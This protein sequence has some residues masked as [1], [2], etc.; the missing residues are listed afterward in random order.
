MEFQRGQV[1]R[2]VRAVMRTT[3]PR[4]IWV[5][6]FYL[7][8]VGLVG[9]VINAV[10][11]VLAGG[12]IL[13]SPDLLGALLTNNYDTIVGNTGPGPAVPPGT[14]IYMTVIALV[15]ALL[16]NLWQSAMQVGY[17][18]YSMDL[19]RGRNPG[20]DKLFAMLRMA[21]PI[22]VTAF[23]V[24]LFSA[25]WAILFYVAG[26]I[27]VGIGAA[28]MVESALTILGVVLMIVALVGMV[29][30]ILWAVL[31]YSMVTY[32]IADQGISG[33][34]AIRES[35]R[36]MKGNLLKYVGLHLS[37]IL[38]YLPAIIGSGFLALTVSTLIGETAA[39]AVVGIFDESH[40]L[41][42]IYGLLGTMALSGLLLLIQ[43]ILN[44]YL[45]PY[46]KGTEA[47]F[48]FW[49][50]GR[51]VDDGRPAYDPPMPPVNGPQNSTYTW[52]DEFSS[53]GQGTYSAAGYS[54]PPGRPQEP[55]RELPPQPAPPETPPAPPAQSEAPEA[56]EKPNAP[57]DPWD[58]PDGSSAKSGGPE[59]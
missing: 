10:I 22:I 9:G 16:T 46:V 2:E 36:L 37:F 7:F 15:G 47:R 14:A 8:I 52:T 5:T 56:P 25:L 20:I 55:P 4:P 48:Y 34:E 19:V 33:L 29:I 41:D 24:G 31:R 44:L 11:S 12:G 49:L 45:T 50:A 27:V 58:R 42:A 43:I 38:W 53:S 57:E 32:L 1:K 39:N 3:R 18:D 54:E 13:T 59:A 40:I 26:L 51:E 28:L 21:W 6:L 17:A 23:L 35:K 30:G